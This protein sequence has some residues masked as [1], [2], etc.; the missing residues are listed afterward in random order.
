MIRV[1]ACVDGFNLYFGLRARYGRRHHWLDLQALADSLLRP[2]QELAEVQYFTARV[3]NDPDG[4]LRQS[5]YLDALAS[6]CPRV[7]TIEARLQEKSRVCKNCGASWIGYEEKETD[8]NIAVALI[9]DAVL[10]AYD[11]AILVSGDSDLRPGIASVKR[12]RPAKR[13]I[14]AFPPNRH[15][16]V[17][18]QAV[19]AYVTISDTKIRNAQLPPKVATVGGVV[20][21]RPEHWN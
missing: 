16:R 13:I 14:S 17:L 21:T 2:G 1:V 15:S 3:R 10:D 20:L 12:L 6:Y 9:E 18:A 7:R 4:S 8:V 19:D 5:T 11:T